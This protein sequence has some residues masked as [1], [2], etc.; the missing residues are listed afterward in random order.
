MSG[1]ELTDF[2]WET[3]YILNCYLCWNFPG[4]VVDMLQMRANK[5]E[6]TKI[7]QSHHKMTEQQ[8]QGGDP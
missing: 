4:Q 8:A 3:I 7:T 2:Q 5:R 1:K 6:R